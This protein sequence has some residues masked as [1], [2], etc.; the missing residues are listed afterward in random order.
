MIARMAA[1]NLFGTITDNQHIAQGYVRERAAQG[2]N[3]NRKKNKRRKGGLT[4]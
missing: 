4:I 2:G 1:D 3:I